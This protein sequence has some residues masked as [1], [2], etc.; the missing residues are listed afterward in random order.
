M[1]EDE[2][3]VAQSSAFLGDTGFPSGPSEPEIEPEEPGYA[4]DVWEPEPQV[5][6]F[7][8]PD[9]PNPP[10]T[11][12]EFEPHVKTYAKWVMHEY[13]DVLPLRW[14]DLTILDDGRFKRAIGKCGTWGYHNARVRISWSH[15]DKRGY[16]WESMQ[17]TIRHE[18]VHA[19]QA[20]WLGYTSHGETFKRK[21]E[22]LDCERLSR[23][24]DDTEPNYVMVCQNCGGSYTRQRECKATRRSDHFECSHCG[25]VERNFDDAEE[26]GG[27]WLKHHNSRSEWE[28]VLD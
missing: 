27:L 16:S 21:A 19:W 10:K 6:D 11:R 8:K 14:D 3:S 22:E 12:A 9:I 5:H 25:T 7:P 23:Y 15:Y 26:L 13:N 2:D 1:K 20:Q 17:E 28:K 18:L 24:D 4:Y